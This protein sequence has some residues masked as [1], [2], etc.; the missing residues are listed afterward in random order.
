VRLFAERG[1]VVRSEVQ[2]VGPPDLRV[3][4][5]LVEPPI[6]EARLV[7]NDRSDR[8]TAA[9]VALDL[10]PSDPGIHRAVL[11]LRTSITTLGD[12]RIPLTA[13]V[14]GAV[15]PVPSHLIWAPVHRGDNAE[16][17]LSLTWPSATPGIVTH[18]RANDPRVRLG[19]PSRRADGAI[20]VLVTIDTRTA[21]T[22][23]T[24]I[25]ATVEWQ[26]TEKVQVPVLCEVVGAAP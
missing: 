22:V 16:R 2:I 21:G 4:S 20:E 25:T 9:V 26:G 23:D 12:V 7:R 17:V 8:R 5:A 6:A 24:T 3:I 1:E 15:R 11:L 18:L 19:V 13:W 14:A 10:L